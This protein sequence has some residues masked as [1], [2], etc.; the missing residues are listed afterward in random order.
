MATSI[1]KVKIREKEKEKAIDLLAKKQIPAVLYGGGKNL[2]LAVNYLDFERLFQAGGGKG[3]IDL[4]VGE[5]MPLKV[6]VQDFD[7]DP[8]T[9][10]FRHIDFRQV[11]MDQKIKTNINLRFMGESPAVKELGAIFVKSFSHVPVECLPQDLVSEIVVDISLLQQLG[12]VIHVKEIIAPPGVKILA[13]AEDVV[14]TVTAP[15]V[16]EEKPAAA[17]VDLSQIK[18]EAEE[19]REKKAAEEPAEEGAAPAKKKEDKK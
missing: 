11:R 18:T 12:N 15:Q 13:H 4:T 14:A 8:L 10:R 7:L 6:L 16:E 19:K 3:L 5:E 1:L 9:N 2:N 17:A